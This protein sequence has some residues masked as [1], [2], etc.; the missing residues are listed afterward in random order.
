MLHPSWGDA[1]VD[2]WTGCDRDAKDFRRLSLAVEVKATRS[3]AP[4]AVR[5]NGE[6][7]LENPGE[8][9]TLLLAVLDV[10]SHQQGA[11]ETLSAAVA[12]TRRLVSG[13]A[14]G[15]LDEKLRAYGHLDS[16]NDVY[17]SRRYELRRML[18]HRIESGFP[19][20]TE[21]DLP[22]GVGRVTYLLSTDAAAPWRIDDDELAELINDNVE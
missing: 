1:A 4:H 5:I 22:D 3:D 10:D 7:Q 2:A 21:A 9:V 6:H 18:W 17:E 20:L 11:G 15:Q 13:P 16:H 8:N 14:L 12:E 19:R